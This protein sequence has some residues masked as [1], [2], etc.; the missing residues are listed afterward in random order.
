LAVDSK[1]SQLAVHHVA[2]GE[3]DAISDDGAD[4]AARLRAIT[5][6]RLDVD[7][8][9]GCGAI[10]VRSAAS[11]EEEREYEYERRRTALRSHGPIRARSAPPR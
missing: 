1:V 9:D 7:D 3:D 8:V 4:T 11:P 6:D 5:T 10:A 2:S